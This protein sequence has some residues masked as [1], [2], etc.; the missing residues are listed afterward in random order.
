MGPS[1]SGKS[2]LLH[3]LAGVLRPES[4]E[5]LSKRHDEIRTGGRLYGQR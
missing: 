3:C 5:V 2:S 4:G 1:G